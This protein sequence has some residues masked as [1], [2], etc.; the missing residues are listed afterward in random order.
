MTKLLAILVSVFIFTACSSEPPPDL[1]K[2]E[3]SLR[4]AVQPRI[5]RVAV[6]A[7]LANVRTAIY[8]YNIY[9]NE[10]PKGLDEVVKAGFLRIT[11]V[12][13][14]WGNPFAF[15]KEKKKSSSQWMEE[16]EIFVFSRGPDGKSGN[17]DDIYL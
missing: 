17:A 12:T 6:R 5:D 2:R 4:Q 1:S 8:Q 15:R 11:D 13:D 7:K 16:Y 14:P 10:I 9:N 3:R